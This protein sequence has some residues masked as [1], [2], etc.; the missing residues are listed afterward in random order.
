METDIDASQCWCLVEV[1]R[2]CGLNHVDSK[3][4]G[5]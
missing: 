4:S 2:A 1:D 5:S 3:D